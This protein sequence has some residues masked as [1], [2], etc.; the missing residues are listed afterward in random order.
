M[1]FDRRIELD[2]QYGEVW[3]HD[4][5]S[6]SKPDG[7]RRLRPFVSIKEDSLGYD[8]KTVDCVSKFQLSSL[9]GIANY[10]PMSEHPLLA[11]HMP[12]Y[13]LPNFGL[14]EMYYINMDRRPDRA[15]RVEQHA[16]FF[17]LKLKRFSAV[18]G[19]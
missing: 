12:T 9:I 19:R 15:K 3:F 8:T 13:F 1:G 5:A 7:Q 14:D 2:L 11:D 17:D 18:D 6:N 4:E 16:K 10:S